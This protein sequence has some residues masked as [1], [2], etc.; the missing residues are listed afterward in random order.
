MVG[1][2]LNLGG[3]VKVSRALPPPDTIRVCVVSCA[4]APGEADASPE[5][6]VG[7]HP[8]PPPARAGKVLAAG[9]ARALAAVWLVL[10]EAINK[11]PRCQWG[12]LSLDLAVADQRFLEDLYDV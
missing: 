8:W 7:P 3:R 11:A 9:R 5:S 1:V 4:T 6:F 2:A 12:R 10:P